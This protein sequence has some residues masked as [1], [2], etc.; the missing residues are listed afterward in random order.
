MGKFLILSLAPNGDKTT[1]AHLST[2]GG[3]VIELYPPPGPESNAIVNARPVAGLAPT[4]SKSIMEGP[5]QSEGSRFQP[6]AAVAPPRARPLFNSSP[7]PGGVD[8]ARVFRS[9]ASFCFF[10]DVGE[11]GRGRPACPGKPCA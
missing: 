8:R 2:A 10:L 1:R 9:L 6:E 4:I 5:E 7:P 3:T 11:Q